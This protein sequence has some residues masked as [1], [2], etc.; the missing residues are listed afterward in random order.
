MKYADFEHI[1][2]SKRLSNYLYCCGNDTRKAMTLYRFNLRVSQEM[3]TIISCFEVA[4]RNA[5][6]RTLNKRLG[7]DWLRDSVQPGGIFDTKS[8]SETYSN[9]HKEY[10]ALAAQQKYSHPNLLSSL[11]FGTWKHMFASPQF[12][13][14][15]KRLMSVFPQKPQSVRTLIIN[16]RSIYKDLGNINVLRNRIAHHE[17]I[18]FNKA[19]NQIDTTYIR[20]KYSQIMRLY[21]WMGIDSGALLY[22]LDHVMRTCDQIDRI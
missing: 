16:Q 22:G 18:C 2:S 9:I 4:L 20:D 8:T 17:P 12:N 21:G 5:I 1:I 13:A 6:D 3:F 11:S 14:T 15:G 19:K 7:P 10:C